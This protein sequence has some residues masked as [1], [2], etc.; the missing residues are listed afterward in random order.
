MSNVEDFITERIAAGDPAF[1]GDAAHRAWLAWLRLQDELWPYA[2][3]T[4][5]LR[6]LHGYDTPSAIELIDATPEVIAAK[7]MWLRLDRR[8]P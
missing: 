5:G 3:L 8:S 2:C 4:V 7:Q 6:R 1:A